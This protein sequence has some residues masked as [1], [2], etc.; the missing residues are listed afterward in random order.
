[1]PADESDAG[2]ADVS[3]GHYH[4]YLDTTD[5][6]ADHITAFSDPL[7]FVLPADIEPGAHTLRISLRA[8]DHHEIG[9]EDSV[10]IQV[11]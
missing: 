6:A 3:T 9:V 8:T 5:D 4:I 10:T 1:M 11:D 2:H 7:E